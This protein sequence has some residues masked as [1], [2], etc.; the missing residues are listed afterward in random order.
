MKAFPVYPFE[1]H[2][3]DEGLMQHTGMD[4][5]DYFA[6]HA[7]EVPTHFPIKHWYED[8]VEET[9]KDGRPWYQAKR[10][11][12]KETWFDHQIRWRYEYA[13]AMMK[14]REKR[15]AP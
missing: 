8:V 14:A 13:D 1:Y 7:P 15:D 4:L 12:R 9:L 6:A 2:D 3:P 5:R 11:E 10:V